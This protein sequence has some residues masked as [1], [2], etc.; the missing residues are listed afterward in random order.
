MIVPLWSHSSVILCTADLHI[1][2]TTGFESKTHGYECL[3]LGT[4]HFCVSSVMID[5][6]YGGLLHSV[7]FIS[8]Y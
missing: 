2:V 7:M 1:F 8:D 6:H 5:E 4:M 3:F